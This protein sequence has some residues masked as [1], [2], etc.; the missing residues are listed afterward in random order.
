MRR[1]LRSLLCIGLVP[2][3]MFVKRPAMRLLLGYDLHASARIGWSLIAARRLVMGPGAAIGS[4][5]VV[6]GIDL[7]M[8]ECASIGRGNWITGHPEGDRSV[9]AQR[10]RRALLELGEH[11]AIT[12]RH[13]LD[14]TAQITIGRFAT[15]A[16]WMSQLLTHSID[17]PSSRQDCHP[18]VIGAY[19]FVGT[20][21][22]VLGGSRL[23]DRSVLGAA[24]LLNKELTEEG[25][26]YGG[27]PA[28]KLKELPPGMAYFSR[29][30]GAV[31]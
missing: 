8:G 18:I 19:C 31:T 6:K 30:A 17:L 28:K 27:V 23:P 3:P 7:V 2:M 20:R 21:V 13:L 5:T 16:G 10:E 14:C 25:C 4:F 24:S 11:S 12:H 26:L 15:V 29:A 9:F 1:L 22:V